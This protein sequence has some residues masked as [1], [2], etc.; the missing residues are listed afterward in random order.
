MPYKTRKEY[1]EEI[2]ESWALPIEMQQEGLK[3]ANQNLR[4][5]LSGERFEEVQE[6]I[7]VYNKILQ[8]HLDSRAQEIQGLYDLW[9]KHAKFIRKEEEHLANARRARKRA[10][11]VERAKD[12]E[13][14]IE[15]HTEAIKHCKEKRDKKIKKLRRPFRSKESHTKQ[16]RAAGGGKGTD[17]ETSQRSRA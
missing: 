2:I 9:E 5:R 13:I 1:K 11:T 7:E 12:C 6:D 8:S 4:Y 16:E 10:T 14:W 15:Y 17:M 3:K